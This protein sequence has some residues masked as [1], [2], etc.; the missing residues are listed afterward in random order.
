MGLMWDIQQ[1]AGIKDAQKSADS[2]RQLAD[3]ATSDQQNLEARYERLS[4]VCQAMWKILRDSAGVT[5][6]QLLAAIRELDLS[7]GALDGKV[8]PTVKKCSAC[9]RV[10]NPRHN[11]CIYC[12]E[13]ALSDSPFEGV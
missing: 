11:K 4:L 7:D 1:F 13:E 5:N 9:H 8:A 12:G 2:A 3:S 6:E 10:M